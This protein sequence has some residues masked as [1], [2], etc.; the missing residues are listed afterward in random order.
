MNVLKV[1]RLRVRM[2]AIFLFIGLLYAS[3]IPRCVAQ[4]GIGLPK[5][6]PIQQQQIDSIDLATLNIHLDLPIFRKNQ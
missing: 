5:F 4:P 6:A 1:S 2:C 3:L